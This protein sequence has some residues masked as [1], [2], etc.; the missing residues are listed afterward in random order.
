MPRCYLFINFLLNSTEQGISVALKAAVKGSVENKRFF[1]ALKLSDA[2]FIL[3]MPT[4]VG[5]LTFMDRI[6]TCF[7]CKYRAFNHVD[8][9]TCP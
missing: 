1:L 6:T 4:R 2:V 7:N 5:I 9:V 8:K 3:L